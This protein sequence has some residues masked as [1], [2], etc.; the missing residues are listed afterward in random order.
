MDYELQHPRMI[1]FKG[2]G[3]SAP[4]ND[5]PFCVHVL[6]PL[7]MDIEYIREAKVGLTVS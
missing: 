6:P 4:L 7:R 2:L 3:D 1:A 5:L